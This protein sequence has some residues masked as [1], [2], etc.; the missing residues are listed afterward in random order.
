MSMRRLHNHL[1]GVEQGSEMLFSDFAEDGPMWTG[2]GAREVRYRVT[3]SRPF[4][5]PPVILTGLALLDIDTTANLRLDLGHDGVTAEGVDLVLKTW[6]DSRIARIRADWTAIG[7][8]QG[9]DEWD[10]Y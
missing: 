3:F 6:G 4:R 8:L 5:A 2:A 9:P 7:E 1:I 10:L